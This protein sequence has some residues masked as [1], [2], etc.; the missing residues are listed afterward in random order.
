MN[1]REIHRVLDPG[2]SWNQTQTQIW[3][4]L[5]SNIP[6]G[7]TQSLYYYLVVSPNVTAPMADASQI[8][9]A[10]DTFEGST[11]NTS[12]WA[13]AT[14]TDGPGSQSVTVTGGELVLT[15]TASGSEMRAQTVRSVANWQQDAIAIDAAIRTDS[16]LS[17]GSNC[18]Q[19]FL[20]GLWAP[21][22]STF[23]RSLF[24]HDQQG[25]RYANHRDSA[26]YDFLVQN[27]GSR[28]NSA[29][30]RRYSMR[31]RGPSIELAVNETA[32]G[33]FSTSSSSITQPSNGPLIAGFEAVAL[34]GCPGVQSHLAID[35]VM[36]R[37]TAR[38]EP[39]LTLRMDQSTHRDL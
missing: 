8:F 17:A 16:N 11:L 19:E 22:P 33:T 26:P 4:S 37:K 12:M 23:I 30:Q 2:S 36:V 15:A 24:L 29:A 25:Y 38:A 13:S 39:S 6:A 32:L 1:E 18:T 5:D 34:G 28:L 31:W 14:K 9:L 3:F 10:Y 7:Q 21:S 20:T 35:W 27:T